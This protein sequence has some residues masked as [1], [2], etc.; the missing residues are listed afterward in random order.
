MDATLWI[1][2]GENRC[3]F[4]IEDVEEM[5]LQ[6]IDLTG[7]YGVMQVPFKIAYL[8]DEKDVL[9]GEEAEAFGHA[10]WAGESIHST[11]DFLNKC[12][13]KIENQ[14]HSYTIRNVVLINA[15]NFETNSCDVL[16]KMLA[17]RRKFDIIWISVKEAFVGYGYREKIHEGTC[18]YLN[19]SWSEQLFFRYEDLLR[20]IISENKRKQIALQDIDRYY[21]NQLKEKHK[22]IYGKE[23]DIDAIR[24]TFGEQKLILYRQMQRAEDVNLYTSIEYPPQKITFSYTSFKTYFDRWL[25]LNSALIEVSGQKIWVSGG[26]NKEVYWRHLFKGYSYEYDEH[27]LIKGA[28]T[29]LDFRQEHNKGLCT[30]TKTQWGYAI[31]DDKKR[32]I[33]FILPGEEYQKEYVINILLTNFECKVPFLFLDQDMTEK[34]LFNLYIHPENE[35]T[36]IE[37]SLKIS[38]E[39]QIEEV[40]YEYRPL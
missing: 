6:Y 16:E 31:I 9:C 10:I 40:K 27:M 30:K 8:E 25:S 39:G 38:I 3:A 24:R 11:F 12:M 7:G 32:R 28:K 22:N 29:F 15:I 4:A 21:L 1:E 14:Y 18:I 36:Q 37:I 26:Y 33:P 5:T 13:G 2:L 19:E 35:R 20:E 17:A 23:V 34:H